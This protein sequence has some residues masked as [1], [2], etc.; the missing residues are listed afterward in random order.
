MGSCEP[1]RMDD[2]VRWRTSP[3]YN[4]ISTTQ[5]NSIRNA[6]ARAF[7]VVASAPEG[8]WFHFPG[9]G[10]R[11]Y[12]VL[13]QGSHYHP[14]SCTSH[15]TSFFLANRYVELGTGTL[16]FLLGLQSRI[17]PPRLAKQVRSGMTGVRS[18]WQHLTRQHRKV[19]PV[20]SDPAGG[21]V[22]RQWDL[23]TLWDPLTEQRTRE[24]AIP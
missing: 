13:Y 19:F 1:N 22:S 6:T 4:L 23:G 21:L 2:R 14:R 12:L 8:R 16:T 18:V 7:F 3:P 15:G 5:R 9:H 24:E 10:P 17:R 11:I 20:P